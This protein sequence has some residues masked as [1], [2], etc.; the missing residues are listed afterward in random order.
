M[1]RM[2]GPL[3][4]K[5]AQKV[6]RSTRRRRSLTATAS[7]SA[8]RTGIASRS[9]SGWSRTIPS[10]TG[11]SAPDFFDLQLDRV[12]AD[13]AAR[14]ELDAV[15]QLLAH[16]LECV[17][18]VDVGDFDGAERRAVMADEPAAV[19]EVLNGAARLHMAPRSFL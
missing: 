4:R 3:A 18:A 11:A 8:I 7:S 17:V 2:P 16:L 9:S 6:S 15:L 12:A 5:C 10:V 14:A 19:G 1:S 13:A